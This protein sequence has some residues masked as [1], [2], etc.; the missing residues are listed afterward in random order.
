M[1]KGQSK[2]TI[3]KKDNRATVY[4]EQGRKFALVRRNEDGSVVLSFKN[5]NVIMAEKIADAVCEALK[6]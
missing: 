3:E 2:P 1:Q 4:D 6:K 5:V